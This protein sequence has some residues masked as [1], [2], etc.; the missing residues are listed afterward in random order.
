MSF[1]RVVDGFEVDYLSRVAAFTQEHPAAV[2]LSANRLVADAGDTNV[3]NT[4]PLRMFHRGDR[5]L[6]LEDA[7]EVI[8][9]DPTSTFFRRDLVEEHQVR[10]HDLWSA[11]PDAFD[12]S[13]RLLLRS[14]QPGGRTDAFGE[15]PPA[16]QRPARRPH[17]RHAASCRRRRADGGDAA[18]ELPRHPRRGRRPG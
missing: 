7:P 10:F 1:P 12:F 9:G 11:A 18:R 17:A 4:H 16:T 14:P 3:S 2:L 5:T 8:V 6:D 15:V 13:W